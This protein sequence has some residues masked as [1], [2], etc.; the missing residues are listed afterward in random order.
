MSDVGVPVCKCPLLTSE[1]AFLAN[2]VFLN[3]PCII[4]EG[5]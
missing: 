1:G 5:F 2:G 4:Y 3:L